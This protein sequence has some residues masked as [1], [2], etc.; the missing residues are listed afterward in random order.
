MPNTTCT[1]GQCPLVSH[2]DANIA[3][4]LILAAAIAVLAYLLF[5][6]YQNN[7]KRK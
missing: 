2:F 4:Y 6:Q 3:L 1:T 5:R 7:K